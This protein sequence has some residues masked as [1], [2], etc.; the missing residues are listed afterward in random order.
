MFRAGIK[1]IEGGP[2]KKTLP[3][4]AAGPQNHLSAV[5]VTTNGAEKTRRRE[6]VEGSVDTVAMLDDQHFVSG[7][8]SG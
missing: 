8:D 7:G 6:F 1:S 5:G 4:A 3:A 2:S